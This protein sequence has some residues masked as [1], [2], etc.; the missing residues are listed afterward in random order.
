MT[1]TAQRRM[2]LE[3]Y[4]AYDDGTD[5]RYELLD[6]VLVEMG[7]EST[8]NTK[9]AGFLFSVF[10]EFLI[11]SD[12]IGFKQKIQVRSI[13]VS[14]RDPDLI[15]HTEASELAI[16]GL[17]E[18]CLK[19]ND[20]NPAIVIE[21]VSPG[22]ED[23][24]NYKRDYEQ[25]PFEYADRSIPEYWMIDPERLLVRIGKLTDGEYQFQEFRGDDLVVSPAFPEFKMTAA[26]IFN[27]GR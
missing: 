6:G 23:S 19:L 5:V 22:N 1:V 7:A 15:I 14:A 26:Q 2:T 10:L 12:R 27:R 9:I 8:L 4:L 11:S 25:K 13:H 3:E 18:A 20:P 24:D 16:E 17:A 21:V